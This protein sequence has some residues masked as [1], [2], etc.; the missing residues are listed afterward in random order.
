MPARWTEGPLWPVVCTIT[1]ILALG[2]AAT[3]LYLPAAMRAAAIEAAYR[4][5]L[6]VADQ[7]K[8]T[9]G[10]YTK[11]V[12]AKALSTGALIPSFLHK[13]DPNAIPLPA[14]F[15]K[16]ISDLL[17]EKETSLSARTHGHTA[18]TE[19]WMIS[20]RPPGRRSSRTQPL[21]SPAR[22]CAMASVFC[23]WPSL[24]A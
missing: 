12:V 2:V 4:S 19:S 15:V 11:Y 24:T 10:Y 16:D 20:N 1:A 21:S 23:E 9:R 8:L 3:A 17:M 13:E 14:T 5:N 6:A 18:P 7:I 22:R